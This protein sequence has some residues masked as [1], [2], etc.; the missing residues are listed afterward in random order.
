[1]DWSLMKER[2]ERYSDILMTV[3]VLVIVSL[4]VV[5]I[6]P[7]FMDYFIAANLS[8]SILIL[9]VAAT[10]LLPLIYPFVPAG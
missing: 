8:I 6:P 10:F 2:L 9:L 4:M 1:M 5:R 7:S 3:G